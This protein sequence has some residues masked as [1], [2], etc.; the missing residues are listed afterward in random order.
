MDDFGK[1]KKK[2][3]TL[4]TLQIEPNITTIDKDIYDYNF[5]LKRALDNLPPDLK[6]ENKKKLTIHKPQIA[7]S[8]KSTKVTNFSR[9]CSSIGINTDN[10]HLIKFLCTQ[11][12]LKKIYLDDNDLIIGKKIS[13]EAIRDYI[14]TYARN[15]KK[16]STCKNFNTILIKEDRMHHVKCLTCTAKRCVENDKYY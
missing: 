10:K 8:N 7:I 13:A 9:I 11:I 2:K 16:C 6:I 3:K 5:L 1:K 12:G 14:C 4:A 15:Y